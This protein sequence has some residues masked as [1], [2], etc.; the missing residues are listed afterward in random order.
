METVNK[1]RLG[2]WSVYRKSK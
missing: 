2:C 1:V